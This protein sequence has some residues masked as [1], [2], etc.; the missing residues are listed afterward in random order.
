MT[1]NEAK[2]KPDKSDEWHTESQRER[3]REKMGGGGGG[4]ER[5]EREMLATKGRISVIYNSLK[6]V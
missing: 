6:V 4:V 3:E 1:A 5:R 2:I